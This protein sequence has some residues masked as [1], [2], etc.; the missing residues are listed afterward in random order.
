MKDTGIANEAPVPAFRIAILTASDKGSRGEREDKSAAVIREMVAG[1]G[2]VV[3]YAVV[4]D[5]RQI[6]AA[7]LREFCDTVGVDLILTTGGTGFS[8]RD[9]TPEATRDVIEREVPGL[10]EAM[11]AASLKATPHAMLS[12]AIAGIR[13]KTLIIN[14]PGSPKGVRENLATILPA[15]PHGLAIL[16]GEV[17]ECGRE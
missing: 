17:G 1:L 15:L 4:P 11:R 9:V 10:P 16:K 3:A 12:R 7:K 14:L 8:P 13:G 2:E 5:E 6:L